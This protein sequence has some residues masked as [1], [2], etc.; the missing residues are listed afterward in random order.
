MADEEAERDQAQ[1]TPAKT[2]EFLKAMKLT[3]VIE[4]LDVC[5]C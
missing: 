5:P 1:G 3:K 2:L 4:L